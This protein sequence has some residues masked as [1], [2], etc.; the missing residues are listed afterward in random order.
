LVQTELFFKI[1]GGNFIANF[2]LINSNPMIKKRYLLTSLFLFTITMVFSKEASKDFLSKLHSGFIENKGQIK[3]QFGQE[4]KEVLYVFRNNNLQIQLRKNGFSYEVFKPNT[5]IEILDQMGNLI[6]DAPKQEYTV[7]RIDIDFLGRNKGMQIKS[8]EANAGEIR[9]ASKENILGNTYTKTFRKVVYKNVYPKIDIEFLIGDELGKKNFKYNI[10][11]HPGAD[12]SAIK[13]AILGAKKTEITQLG[14]L[15]F[16]TEGE[17][18]EENIPFSYEL[19]EKGEIGKPIQSK[20]ILLTPNTVGFGLNQ[21]NTKVTRVIDPFL[22]STY[23]GGASNDIS[24]GIDT[25]PDGNVVITGITTSTTNIATAGAY[26]TSLSG[27]SSSYDGFIAKFS[28]NGAL[29]WATYYGGSESEFVL[30]LNVD[31]DGNIFI[32]GQTNSSAGIATTGAHQSSISGATDGFIAKFSP[33]GSLV[34]ATYFGGIVSD[35]INGVV[36][37]KLGNVLVTG[38]SNS[39]FDFGFSGVHQSSNNGSNDAFVL[40]FSKDGVLKKGTYFGGSISETSSAINVDNDFNIYITGYTNSSSNIATPSAYQSALSGNSDIYLAKFDTNMVLIYGTYFGGVNFDYPLDISIDS[41]KRIV[42][43]GY[44][45]SSTDFP[46]KNAYLASITSS[47]P[48]GFIFQ[49]DSLFKLNFS[50]YFGGEFTDIIMGMTLDAADNIYITGY[51]NSSTGISTSGAYQENWRG[52]TFDGVIA[53]FSGS[54]NINWS[55]YFGGEGADYLRCVAVDKSNNLFV[56]G[57][58]YS[59]S[60]VQF[61]ATYQTTRKGNAEPILLKISLDIPGGTLGNNTIGSNQTLCG[62]SVAADLIGSTPTGGTGSYSYTWLQ[63][64]TGLD[65]SFVNANG[66]NTNKDYS[67]GSISSQ[68]YYKR[69][70]TDG[71]AFDTSNVVTI[72]LGSAFHAGFT[73]NKTIQCLRSNEFIFTDTTSAPGLTYDWDFGNGATSTNQSETISYAYQTANVYRVRLITSFGGSCADTN[74]KM[75]YTVSDPIAKNITGIDQVRR[76]DTASYFIPHTAGSRY[77]W[78]FD[79]G[80]LK[81]NGTGNQIQIKWTAVGTTQLKVVE[82][83]SGNCLGDTAFLDITISPA[84]DIEELT[85][86]N[87]FHVYPNPNT[88]SFVIGGL[89]Q[90]EFTVNVYDAR[91]ALVKS[92]LIHGETRIELDN[93]SAGLYVIQLIHPNGNVYQKRMQIAAE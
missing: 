10:I 77:V 15:A 89:N 80:Q 75:V 79:N 76:L 71:S 65:G 64:A 41:K 23:F 3:N 40:R 38:Y 44:T 70:V 55:T 37:D 50:T 60:F 58:C 52:S 73:V 18:L 93:A 92:Q 12:E 30:D 66:T 47:G 84:L 7:S 2:E 59:D 51:T 17:V 22:W 9:Y 45:Y 78:V 31:G 4:N 74:Y 33:T 54:G 25:D 24:R 53:S 88:G 32:V 56:I 68:T 14:N 57:D 72:K 48:L 8:L 13:F 29:I 82:T 42:I 83:S 20:Y 46:I 61:G 27:T 62:T 28:T 87:A 35:I 90:K 16:T 6:M 67:P 49:M 43:A 19:T 85:N 36:T 26:Q 63:S 5:S 81:G 21:T 34:W 1:N 86:E 69:V 39:G 91:G 11:L